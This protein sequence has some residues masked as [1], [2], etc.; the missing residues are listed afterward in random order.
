MIAIFAA[1]LAFAAPSRAITSGRSVAVVMADR[2]FT[3]A[4]AKGGVE[5]DNSKTAVIFIEYQNEFT[6]EG[7]KVLC[8]FAASTRQC[9]CDDLCLQSRCGSFIPR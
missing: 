4:D 7:G 3:P 2:V 1:G 8:Q 5:V 6:T 9:Q